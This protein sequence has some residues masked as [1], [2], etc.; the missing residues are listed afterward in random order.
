MGVLN[1]KNGD[2]ME[3]DAL[4]NAECGPHFSRFVNFIGRRIKLAGWIGYCGGL[5]TSSSELT[6]EQSVVYETAEKEH[7]MYHVA[8][9][10]PCSTED[11]G[12]VARKSFTGNDIINILF[13][14]EGQ[15]GF[16]LGSMRSKQTQCLIIARMKGSDTVACTVFGK[17][18]IALNLAAFMNDAGKIE[19]RLNPPSETERFVAMCKN[20]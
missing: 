16:K 7:V 4:G 11:V 5:D 14:E 15:G 12:C 2:K 20:Q 1:V 10:I 13:I 19:F 18:G 9:W 3:Q 17:D 6:G 8:P